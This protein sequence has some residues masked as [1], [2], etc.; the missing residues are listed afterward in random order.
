VFRPTNPAAVGHPMPVV[1]FGNGA[2]AHTNNN[3]VIGALTFIASHGF[4]VVDIGSVNNTSNGLSSGSPMPSLLTDAISWAERENA[5]GGAAL[6]QR[7]DLAK[8]AVAGHSCGG[9]EALVAAEDARVKSV[10]SLD[11]GFFS[12]GSFGY[13]RSELSKLHTPA[14]FMDGGPSDI[15]YDNTRA[16][17][18]LATVPSV[19]AEQ[20][21]AGHT[22]FIFGSQ[23]NEGMTVV[24]QFL[25]FTLNG[26]ASARSYILGPGGLATRPN[27]TVQSKNF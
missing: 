4:V 25:D 23:M 11:S 14:L 10:V 7:L 6:Y 5:R 26:T 2:C 21:Q 17:Y 15:A 18:N 22:G 27:W 3:E 1:A 13:P 8:V 16:N 24:V 12:D 19:L 20:S 9:L